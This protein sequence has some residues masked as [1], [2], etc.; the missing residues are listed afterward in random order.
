MQ[1]KQQREGGGLY[2]K[3]STVTLLTYMLNSTRF[4]EIYRELT[5]LHYTFCFVV[6]FCI[7]KY[8]IYIYEK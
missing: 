8:N 7:Y 5:E 3:E 1:K 2:I 6:Q 4:D